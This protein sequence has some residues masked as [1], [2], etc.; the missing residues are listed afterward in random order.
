KRYRARLCVQ[1][2]RPLA[3]SA[4]RSVG[5]VRAE[6]AR[7]QRVRV[8]AFTPPHSFGVSERR[9]RHSH[10]AQMKAPPSTTGHTPAPRTFFK[11]TA[12]TCEWRKSMDVIATDFP[13]WL[14]AQHLLNFVLMGML[15]RSG[16]EML[17]S[18]PR[19]WWRNDCAPGSEWLKFTRRK[20]PKEEGVYTSLMDEK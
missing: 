8:A 18:L 7:D 17:S 14:R 15:I 2:D 1:S 11:T 4:T 10:P 16:I 6:S 5:F 12:V 19:L 9:Q 13:L 3:G 20:L